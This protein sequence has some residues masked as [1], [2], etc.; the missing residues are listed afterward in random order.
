MTG[1][2]IPWC[3]CG[4][5]GEFCLVNKMQWR[6]VGAASKAPSP[7][8]EGERIDED[9]LERFRTVDGIKLWG[10]ISVCVCVSMCEVIDPTGCHAVVGTPQWGENCW[11]QFSAAPDGRGD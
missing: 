4:I 10:C 1:G 8:A 11:R 5:F 7:A 2:D 9:P 6:T 3:R